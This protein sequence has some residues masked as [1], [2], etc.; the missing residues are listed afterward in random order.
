MDTQILWLL[1]NPAN[2]PSQLITWT[3]QWAAADYLSAYAFATE[4]PCTA[5]IWPFTPEIQIPSFISRPSSNPSVIPACP[6]ARSLA[7]NPSIKARFPSAHSGWL[8]TSYTDNVFIEGLLFLSLLLAGPSWAHKNRAC[9]QPWK[10]PVP[11]DLGN[12]H[13]HC[14]QLLFRLY[15]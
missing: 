15:I 6:T 3:L 9:P 11:G 1:N 4:Q 7:L 13:T 8:C 5:C 14:A 2:S 10:G 12:L